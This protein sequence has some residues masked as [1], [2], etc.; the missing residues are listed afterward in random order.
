[1]LTELRISHF[2]LIDQLHVEFPQGFLV[3]TGE[4]GAGKSLVIDA[5]LLLAGG[6]AATD[7]IRFNA[8]EALLEASFLLPDSH[9]SIPGLREDGYLLADQTEILVRRIISRSGKNRIYLNGQLASLQTLQAFGEQLIDI[10]GQHDQQSLLSPKTQQRLLDAFGNLQ[11][12]VQVYQEHFAAWLQK[13]KALQSFREKVQDQDHRQEIVEYQLQELEEGNLQE[14]EVEALQEE[15]HR[16]KYADRLR[17]LSQQAYTVLSGQD[18][19]LLEQL[20][21]VQQWVRELSEIDPQARSWPALIEPIHIP[22]EELRNALR[23][24][25]NHV[26]VDPNR[27][28]FIDARLAFLQRIQKKYGK[29]IKELLEMIDQ[30]HEELSSLV[31]RDAH[32]CRLEGEVQGAEETVRKLAEDLSR[33]RQQVAK[34]LEKAVKTE[35]QALH[36]GSVEYRVKVEPLSGD[37][38]Y[39][40]TGKDRTEMVFSANP[41]EPLMPIEKI[42]SGGE[43]SRIM[44]ALKTVFAEHDQIPV[45]IFD[46]VDSGV[47]GE[48]GRVMGMRLRQLAKFHQ[49]CCVTHL[50]QI[51]SQGHAHYVVEKTTK[52]ERTQ[53]GVVRIEGMKRQNEIARMLGGGKLTPTLRKTAEEM[54]KGVS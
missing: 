44:L 52:G 15:Y 43:L 25:E 40:H 7:M 31:D 51:A 6:R 10:H 53:T 47:G 18:G 27:M 2:A 23:E 12:E 33:K 34:R 3:F 19:S 11:H 50:P 54:L 37:Q 29:T 16:V 9:P 13:R 14:G 41:G 28:D 8:E 4:T 36:M 48:V 35:L 46:E 24:Y 49:V 20:E 30:L 39:G 38:A 22:L 17:V 42:A 45:V 21:Q 1:M 32:M 26:E 5:L